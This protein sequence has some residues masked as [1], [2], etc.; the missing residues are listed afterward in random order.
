MIRSKIAANCEL[1]GPKKEIIQIEIGTYEGTKDGTNYTVKDYTISFDI[2]GNEIKQLINTKTVFYD[3]Q[4]IIQLNNYLENTFDYS[5][6]DKMTRDWTKI[7]QGLLLDTQTNLYDY[8]GQQLT[9]YRLNPND[10]ELC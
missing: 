1:R 10:W 4:K 2:E 5:G 6:M 3:A 9:I 8:E 7:A